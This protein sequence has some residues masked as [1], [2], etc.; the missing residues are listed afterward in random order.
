MWN[1]HQRGRFQPFQPT[2]PCQWVRFKQI[3]R[4]LIYAQKIHQGVSIT[5]WIQRRKNLL[6][7]GLNATFS[8]DRN[9]DPGL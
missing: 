2:W 9:S 7:P 8:F 6:K 5:P 1:S 3:I 4:P